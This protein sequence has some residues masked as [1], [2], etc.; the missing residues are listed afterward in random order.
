MLAHD[1]V[2]AR[3]TL[4]A[5]ATREYGWA[6]EHGIVCVCGGGGGVVCGRGCAFTPVR[7]FESVCVCVF[8]T[9]A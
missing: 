5:L 1:C 9:L 2:H 6:R 4:E 3:K 7:E 8:F